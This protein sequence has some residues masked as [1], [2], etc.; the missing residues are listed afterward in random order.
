MCEGNAAA[1]VA[2]EGREPPLDVVEREVRQ[3]HH[4]LLPDHHAH[5]AE[6]GD[7]G[8]QLGHVHGRLEPL[9]E[10][11]ILDAPDVAFGQLVGRLR[12]CF[13]D[14]VKDL[15]AGRQF[16]G[17]RTHDESAHVREK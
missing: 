8:F 12:E 9:D 14:L 1:P 11:P 7:G 10:V 2:R 16:K 4:R 15:E 6:E 3:S 13:G 17:L 5:E